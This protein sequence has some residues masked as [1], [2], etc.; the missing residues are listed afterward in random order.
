MDYVTKYYK[1]IAEGRIV[2]SNRV[3]KMYKKLAEDIIE[4]NDYHADDDLGYHSVD[5]EHA[6]TKPE[7][8]KKR[9]SCH[10]NDGSY[11]SGRQKLGKLGDDYLARPAL[12]AEHPQLVCNVSKRNRA[13]DGQRVCKRG[14]QHHVLGERAED[15]RKK[16][17]RAPA[18]DGRHY[19]PKE[20]IYYLL[21]FFI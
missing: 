17:V 15:K 13:R 9:Y 20:I 1:E 11:S 7:S 2:T 16:S 21:I 12:A 5:T 10:L 19:S 8:D 3:A 4:Q 14:G 18:D 6:H